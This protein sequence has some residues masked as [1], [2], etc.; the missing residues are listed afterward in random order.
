MQMT[1]V[2]MTDQEKEPL[3]IPS[4]PQKVSDD[5]S[6]YITQ[7]FQTLERQLSVATRITTPMVELELCKETAGISLTFIRIS[8]MPAAQQPQV[9]NPQLRDY[10]RDYVIAHAVR[11][12]K[13]YVPHGELYVH[14]VNGERKPNFNAGTLH[15]MI[16]TYVGV[17]GTGGGTIVKINLS[18]T[19]AS[20]I[21]S[22]KPPLE[23]SV[24]F[25]EHTRPQNPK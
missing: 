24:A 22:L 11:E 8:H 20:L 10:R 9:A 14:F 3:P 18:L 6:V 12:L 15:K 5:P 7:Y 13:T 21:I 23:L 16:Q 1:P 4:I 25:A 2:P 17:S 19:K